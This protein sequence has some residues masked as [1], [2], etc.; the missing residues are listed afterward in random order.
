MKWSEYLHHVSLH[1]PIVLSLVLAVVG[2]WWVKTGDARLA[3]LVRW[4]GWFTFGA[5]TVAALSGILAAP[6]WFG[7]DG[8]QGLSDHRN[9]GVV[10]WSVV[11]TAAVAFELGRRRGSVYTMRFGALCWCAAAFSAIGAGHWG[12]SALHSDKIPWQGTKP[13][14]SEDVE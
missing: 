7:G 9:M 14:L 10:T 12:G 3:T 2:P 8:P 13:I 1:F 4:A 6:G 11:A 5:T